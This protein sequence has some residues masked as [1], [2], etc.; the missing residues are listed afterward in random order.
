[1]QRK[2]SNIP[3]DMWLIMRLMQT[4]KATG[5]VPSLMMAERN[6]SNYCTRTN[7]EELTSAKLMTFSSYFI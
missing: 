7:T 2:E 3:V 5:I 6:G 4:I 1:M